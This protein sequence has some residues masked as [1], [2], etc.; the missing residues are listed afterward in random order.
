MQLF[1]GGLDADTVVPGPKT[2]HKQGNTKTHTKEK[3][4]QLNEKRIICIY[5]DRDLIGIHP[6]T[7]R[8]TFLASISDCEETLNLPYHLIHRYGHISMHS[9]LI[10]SHI[11]IIKKWVVDFLN[12]VSIISCATIY[13]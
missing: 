13:A 7:Q 10:D 2:K 1:K 11:Y 8:L 12:T 3:P 4:F 5:T 9:Q 6:E